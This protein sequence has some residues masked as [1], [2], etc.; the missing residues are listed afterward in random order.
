MKLVLVYGNIIPK[1]F[2]YHDYTITM[3]LYFLCKET[4]YFIIMVNI[5]PHI[6]VE[7]S[8]ALYRV[9][10]VLYRREGN[11]TYGVPFDNAYSHH[12]IRLLHIK[13]YL[14]RSCGCIIPIHRRRRDGL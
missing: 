10:T 9:Y 13:D 14:K 1:L 8:N 12:S 7:F 4:S 2:S 11:S 3:V 5:V 6:L